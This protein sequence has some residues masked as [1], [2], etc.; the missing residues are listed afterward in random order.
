MHVCNGRSNDAEAQRIG[1]EVTG[2]VEVVTPPWLSLAVVFG[3]D[4]AL[5]DLRPFIHDDHK[6]DTNEPVRIRPTR[7]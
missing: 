5:A 6:S 4:R 3:G 1:A 7:R 2:P